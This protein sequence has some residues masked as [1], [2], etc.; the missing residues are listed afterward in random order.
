MTTAPTTR[1]LMREGA[2]NC[3]LIANAYLIAFKRIAREKIYQAKGEDVTKSVELAPCSG[4]KDWD[5]RVHIDSRAAVH[6]ELSDAERAFTRLISVDAIKLYYVYRAGVDGRSGRN[7]RDVRVKMAF[8]T[9]CPHWGEGG[10]LLGGTV[11]GFELRNLNNNND[12]QS[13]DALWLSSEEVKD[14]FGEGALPTVSMLNTMLQNARANG[15]VVHEVFASRTRTRTPS[16]PAAQASPEP[17]TQ[18]LALVAP[19][20]VPAGEPGGQAPVA[21]VSSPAA[22]GAPTVMAWTL[23]SM[24]M[25][26]L[27]LLPQDMLVALLCQLL[28][29]LTPQ[30]SHITSAHMLSLVLKQ[31][32]GEWFVAVAPD[33][34]QPLV[35]AAITS[36]VAS[37][38]RPEQPGLPIEAPAAAQPPGSAPRPAAETMAVATQ[39]AAETVAEAVETQPPVEIAA[40]PTQPIRAVRSGAKAAGFRRRGADR[41]IA[42]QNIIAQAPPK[43]RKTA[44]VNVNDCVA[45]AQTIMQLLKN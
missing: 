7:Q 24:D 14:W 40:A 43:R 5:A 31:V 29:Q 28:A 23:Q 30:Q 8:Q 32:P 44:E 27:Q 15:R 16:P 2:E 3:V 6:A 34:V 35:Q 36:G 12:R 45:A 13:T 37:G 1:Q 25:H 39:P 42:K 18:A 9:I 26:Q 38:S 4:G 33:W 20:T 21:A 22:P 17:T 10:E 41:E 19:V 11:M